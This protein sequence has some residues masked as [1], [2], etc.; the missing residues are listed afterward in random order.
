MTNGIAFIMALCFGALVLWDQQMNDGE[1]LI[2][3]G[4]QLL[5]LIEWIAIWR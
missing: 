2:F 4:R 1:L 5:R 3:I